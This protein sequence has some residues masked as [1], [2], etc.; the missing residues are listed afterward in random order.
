MNQKFSGT[1]LGAVKKRMLVGTAFQERK[2]W[3]EPLPLS[4]T[5]DVCFSFFGKDDARTK[6]IGFCKNAVAG[7]ASGMVQFARDLFETATYVP[8]YGNLK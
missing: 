5:F 7:L 4:R 6:A 8:D 3:E 2:T 1:Q